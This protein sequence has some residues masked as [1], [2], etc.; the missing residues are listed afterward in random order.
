M[1]AADSPLGL[2]GA[3]V[4]DITRHLPDPGVPDKC[5]TCGA[6][7]YWPCRFFDDAGHVVRTAKL[8]VRALVPADLHSRLP[9][10]D[11]CDAP[12]WPSRAPDEEKDHG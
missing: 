6:D 2:V 4:D 10:P 7:A 5:L 9:P 12:E 8:P 11:S 3:A 1:V